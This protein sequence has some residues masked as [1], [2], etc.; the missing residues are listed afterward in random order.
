MKFRL[1]DPE[2][3]HLV[4]LLDKATDSNTATE[5]W[6]LFITICHKINHS[7]QAAK[8]TR[9]VIQ[10]KL[11]TMIPQ[12]QVLTILLLKVITE[13]C[14]RFDEQLGHETLLKILRNVWNRPETHTKV[15]ERITECAFVWIME[16]GGYQ[17]IHPI[18]V[19][20]HEINQLD[21]V[22]PTPHTTT[23]APFS[24]PPLPPPHHQHQQHRQQQQSN[25]SSTI[26][27]SS[28]AVNVNRKSSLFHGW[29]LKRS[30]TTTASSLTTQSKDEHIQPHVSL[31]SQQV[32]QQRQQQRQQQSS[33]QSNQTSHQPQITSDQ[34]KNSENKS[35]KIQACIE[36]SKTTGGLLHQLLSNDLLRPDDSLLQEL[37]QKCQDLQSNIM[38]YI[39]STSD[40]VYIGTLIDTNNLLQKEMESYNNKR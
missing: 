26:I 11:N 2:E 28:G 36:E 39:E 20:S 4:Q 33:L 38:R 32:S 13:N 7:S 10:K 14:R 34:D 27:P 15:R 22:P 12:T 40:P 1:H 24:P 9:K 17:P 3:T 25:R 37:N 21:P 29:K 16:L 35:Q 30:N 19:F 8:T 31:V 23:W 6:T 18:I 5:D